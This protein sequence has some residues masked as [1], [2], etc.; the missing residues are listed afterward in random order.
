MIAES[1]VIGK[2]IYIHYTYYGKQ[3]IE[4][5]IFT[6]INIVKN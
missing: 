4:S 3:I 1:N 6:F 5:P 2:T